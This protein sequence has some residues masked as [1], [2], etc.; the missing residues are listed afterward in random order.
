M[1]PLDPYG[2]TDRGRETDRGE[3]AQRKITLSPIITRLP[4]YKFE[5]V[6]DDKTGIYY[7]LINCQFYLKLL[8]I[9]LI[10]GSNP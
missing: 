9:D 5:I 3:L 10:S 4:Y 7:C 8:F 2:K 1:F 6:K